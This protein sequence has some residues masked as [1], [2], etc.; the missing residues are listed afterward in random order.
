MAVSWI[1][2]PFAVPRVLDRSSCLTRCTSFLRGSLDDC[3]PRILGNAR[4]SVTL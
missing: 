1:K 2:D 4:L 3:A